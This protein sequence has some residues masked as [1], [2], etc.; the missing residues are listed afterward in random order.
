M[1]PV[2]VVHGHGET[3]TAASRNSSLAARIPHRR[4]RPTHGGQ[5]MAS[6]SIGYGETCDFA[7]GMTRSIG[8]GTPITFL[9]SACVVHP[10][11]LRQEAAYHTAYTRMIPLFPCLGR[12]NHHPYVLNGTQ[13]ISHREHLGD[14]ASDAV[15]FNYYCIAALQ[16]NC[17]IHFAVRR[18]YYRLPM[19]T[20]QKA[21]CRRSGA[22]PRHVC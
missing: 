7:C 20:L 2:S 8:S 12:T 15:P 5:Y 22:C 9:T 10:L 4:R 6:P 18:L 3:S 19:A 1:F 16:C 21:H 17:Y 11:T 13:G 14:A